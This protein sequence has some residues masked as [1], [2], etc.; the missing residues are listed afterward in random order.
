[1][2]FDNMYRETMKGSNERFNYIC[3]NGRCVFSSSVGGQ[4]RETN[5]CN[6]LISF[7]N[8]CVDVRKA[9]SPTAVVPLLLRAVI[10]TT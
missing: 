4:E 10:K 1:M 6:A 5:V 8:L 3:M 7:S 2:S 9:W